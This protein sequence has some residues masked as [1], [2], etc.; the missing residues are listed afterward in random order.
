MTTPDEKVNKTEPRKKIAALIWLW[1]TRSLAFVLAL[2]IILSFV[3]L[4]PPVQN[5]MGRQTARV[6]SR[7]MGVTVSMDY[8]YLA[9]LDRV[10]MKGFY[11]ED[12]FVPG[13]TLLYSD[14]L[15][16]NIVTNPFV[17]LWKGLTI[18]E[19]SLSNAQFNLKRPADA[20][21]TNLETLLDRLFSP[22]PAT[23]NQKKRNFN[24]LIRR[25]NLKD[26]RFVKLD[27][28]RGQRLFTA[29]GKGT[30]RIRQM[31][32]PHKKIDARLVELIQ[33][34]VRIDEFP[35]QA[36]PIGTALRIQ[37]ADDAPEPSALLS[38]ETFRLRDGRFALHNYDRAP[39][40]LSPTDELDYQHMEVFDI[41]MDVR[42][43]TFANQVFLGELQHL[44]LQDSSGFVLK[45]LSARE[46]LV[47]PRRA[48]LNDFKLITPYSEI[49]D[50]LVFRY[51]DY[52]KFASFPDDVEMDA[53]INSASVVLRD[54]MTFAP[55]LKNNTFFNS[56][57]EE[58]LQVDGR[59]SGKV[60][61][62]RGRNLNIRLSDGSLVRGNF[63]T[64]NLAV[65]NE[66]FITLRLEQ[67]ST[68]VRTLRQ[69]IPDLNL[70]S[71][72]DRLG[73]LNFEGSFDGFFA[74]FVALGYLRTDIGRA[75][76]DMQMN[77]KNG[78]NRAGYRGRLAL[79]DFDLGKWTDNPDFGLVNFTS[80]VKNGV[81]LSAATASAELTANIQSFVFK[82]Y[83][84][85]NAQLSGKLNRNLFDGNFTIKDEHI[86][87]VFR[88]LLN[89]KDSVPRFNFQANVNKLDLK[90]INFSKKDIVLGGQFDLNLSN[91]RLSTME[92][93]AIVNNLAII[94]NH[95]EK[96]FIEELQAI[97]EFSDDG[98]RRFRLESDVM[99]GLI[100]GV[101]DIEQI[102]EAVI[103]H[104]TR[105]YPAFAERFGFR[106]SSR[107]LNAC[108][109]TFDFRLSDSQ[110]LNHLFDEKLGV[111]R[112][113]DI[114]GRYNSMSDQ[115]L[116]QIE[117]PT[118]NYGDVRLEDAH[119]IFDGD[120]R[121]AHILANS[122]HTV[123]N[124]KYELEPLT[125]T[126]ELKDSFNF[127]IIQE[128]NKFMDALDLE[129]VFFP[130][131]S[132]RFRFN[133]KPN[134]LVILERFWLI[135]P[136]N[137][138]EIGK[139][140]I[141]VGH[142]KLTSGERTMLIESVQDKGLRL[143]LFNL[144]F[145]LIDE[146][147]DYKPLDFGGNFNLIVQATDLFQLQDLRANIRSDSL[148]INNDLFGKFLF[149]ANARDLKSP[150]RATLRID[151]GDEVL[152]AN[153]FLNLNDIEDNRQAL[154]TTRQKH[155]FDFNVNIARYPIC[156]AE[157]FI[158][159]VIS[160]TEG[161]FDGDLRFSGFAARPDVSGNLTL[162]EG[163]LTVDYLKTR[164]TFAEGTV[165]VNNF[166]FG[167][168]DIILR[169]K[170]GH[171]ATV[172]GGIRHDRLRNMGLDLRLRTNRFLALDT[173][174]G[175]NDLFYGHALGAGDIRFN[176]P[177]DRINIYINANVADSTRIV[178]PVSAGRSASAL[179]FV[180]FINK[181]KLIEEAAE[182]ER[183][184]LEPTGISLEMNLG[185]RQEAQ[186]E[187]VFNEQTG[188]IIKGSG[189]GNIR[190]IMPRGADFQMFGDYTIEQGDYL[191][192]LYNVVNKSFRIRQGGNIQWAGDPFGA[193][194]SLEAEYK[195]LNT[196]VANFIQEYLVNSSPQV[197]SDASKATD[198]VLR[199]QLQGDLLRPV[200]NFDIAFPLLIGELKTYTDSK[201]RILKQDQNELN[202][203]V[204][205]L[206]VV[207]QFLPSDFALQGSEILYNT[208]SEFISN[209]LS[210]L[211][212]ELFSDLISEGRV[213][214]G[215]DF[216][217][218]YN[219]YQNVDLGDGQNFSRG[220]EFQVQLRQ[221]FLNDRLTVLLGGNVDIGT[222]VRNTASAGTFVGNDIVI[223]YALSTDRS[224]KLRVYQR[225]QPDIGGRRLQIGSGLSFRREFDSFAEFWKTLRSQTK[226][227][228]ENF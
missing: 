172:S 84:Y 120:V 89:F 187:L 170:Y 215:I 70:P 210:L 106:N 95:Q 47:S 110:G 86:D 157:Y 79:E 43:F 101:F 76:M 202:R 160:D 128:T 16:V 57:Q 6:L 142:F 134:N 179:K 228:E 114:K 4:I 48:E 14:K 71:N 156:I 53:R 178:I 21:Q 68:R 125:I 90:T 100:S 184:R 46:V 200:I 165:N 8:L 144:D 137:Y 96:Y 44:A 66:E 25:L 18:D 164:Y 115:L 177:F 149:S 104:F 81:G 15:S 17:L 22:Q 175:D 35:A 163:A 216:D 85:E 226:K 49:G 103:R 113:I 11:V 12:P 52:E 141:N 102:P 168:N 122:M 78:R 213:L 94:Y 27:Q 193:Q 220:D 130:V 129:G 150:L 190:I 224:L 133:F 131:D 169:D 117:M 217:I 91:N 75:R 176:G 199:M 2:F 92:G 204:F 189:R 203:Q 38:I 111:L 3:L 65:K 23:E 145:S 77:L 105:N 205:G 158:G 124:D 140:Y 32:L 181:K 151:D 98:Q 60:N 69:L 173:K 31:D 62:L 192:T 99:S 223:E 63:N 162:R 72:W 185:I 83:N 28:V 108:N 118:F 227:T 10:V 54:I 9:F 218:A 82:Q 207:G 20:R 195:G 219:Q 45:Q 171:S 87:L 143:S 93:T 26:V 127:T 67:F 183:Q 180:N 197:K 174:K 191:F 135:N 148:Y 40:K 34:V 73:R 29:I 182:R 107:Q 42:C 1:L 5:W 146:F 139:N 194:I 41:N 116:V 225:L 209:Q 112:D 119:L 152:S 208:V 196:S 212:T 61:N 80:E 147:W 56:N 88:G 153:G 50:S 166:L 7:E 123:I 51:R 36:I 136:D 30:I 121:G 132:S 13:D 159:D 58:I 64:R 59:V 33:P 19:V 186:M 221:N 167:A 55:G 97:S 201:L 154:T 39:V 155:Y 109:F 188:D 37:D 214:S 138:I 222:S 126:G 198:V 161:Y 211:L 74:N 24:L 206:I